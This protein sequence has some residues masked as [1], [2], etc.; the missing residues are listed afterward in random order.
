MW[1]SLSQLYE[2]ASKEGDITRKL[3]NKIIIIPVSFKKT[4]KI[5]S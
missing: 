5:D 1:N 3:K 2:K 4:M